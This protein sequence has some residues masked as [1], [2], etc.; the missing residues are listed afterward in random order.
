ML[1]AIYNNF[2][3]KEVND[4]FFEILKES[5]IIKREHPDFLKTS[6]V[7]IDVAAKTNTNPINIIN[8]PKTY[9]SDFCF[10]EN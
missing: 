9:A 7:S 3:E 5:I 2:T 10:L 8:I 1:E 4:L 6:W